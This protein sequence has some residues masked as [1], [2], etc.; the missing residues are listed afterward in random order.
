MV[1]DLASHS[2]VLKHS[3]HSKVAKVTK[4]LDSIKGEVHQ[5]GKKSEVVMVHHGDHWYPSGKLE[6]TSNPEL[7][8]DLSIRCYFE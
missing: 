5:K 6:G 4:N 3:K 8:P 7:S 1:T 2:R